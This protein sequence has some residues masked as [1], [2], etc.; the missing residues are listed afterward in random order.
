[1]AS[2]CSAGG[3]GYSKR[4]AQRRVGDADLLHQQPPLR[5]A[6]GRELAGRGHAGLA[7]A[8][9]SRGDRGFRSMGAVGRLLLLL[10]SV[11]R[12]PVG[13]LADRPRIPVLVGQEF[14][15]SIGRKRVCFAI[16]ALGERRAVD[17]FLSGGRT[18]DQARIHGG[19]PGHATRGRAA[20]CRGIRRH[21]P[22]RRSST[23]SWSPP[24]PLHAGWGMTDRHGYRLCGRADRPARRRA[25]R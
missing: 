3:R 8:S 13:Q 11:T 7:R 21:R 16:V 17:H 10:M 22:C 4:A 2:R 6:M 1:M 23:C 25:F 24:G 9:P 18:G 5:G 12:R 20:D 14:W 19:P 15:V